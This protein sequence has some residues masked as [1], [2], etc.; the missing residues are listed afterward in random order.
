MCIPDVLEERL[1]LVMDI[2]STQS[3]QVGVPFVAFKTSKLLEIGA[4]WKL[5]AQREPSLIQGNFPSRIEYLA[6]NLRVKCAAKDLK[7]NL[8]TLN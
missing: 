4:L 6:K 8:I 2:I 5:E 3:I 7:L 1:Q